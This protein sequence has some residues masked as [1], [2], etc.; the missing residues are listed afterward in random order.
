MERQS[1]S[2]G[3]FHLTMSSSAAKRITI[4]ITFGIA[5]SLCVI[6]ACITRGGVQPSDDRRE[7]P[8]AQ[9]VSKADLEDRVARFTEGFGARGG[10]RIPTRG[11]RR[12]VTEGVALVLDGKETEARTRLAEVDFTVRTFTDT[13]G[14]RRFAEVSDAAARTDGANRGWG[15]VYIDLDAPPRWSVQV[16]HPIA[17]L[18]TERLGARVLRG[19]PGGVLVVA[20]AHRTAGRGDAADVAHRTD[21]VF[22]GV[23]SELMDRGLPG[24]QLHGFADDSFPRFDAVVSTGSGNHAVADARRLAT[25]FGSA[26]LRVC[27]AWERDCKLSGTDNVQG[28][29]ADREDRRFLHVELNTSSRADEAGLEA[30]ARAVATVVDGWAGP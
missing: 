1:W 28:R 23:V 8:R 27:R 5:A 26:G 18:D 30:S 10:Y 9:S 11:E 2:L 3:Y 14:G 16:P 17:D 7:A 12:A 24:V 4:G 22:H 15:R 25:A 20:G 13:V 29:A 21:S 6:V 19:T